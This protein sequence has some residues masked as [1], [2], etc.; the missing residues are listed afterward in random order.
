MLEEFSVGEYLVTLKEHA[1]TCSGTVYLTF[2]VMETG[3]LLSS[4][5]DLKTLLE[6]VFASAR[7]QS[8]F[9]SKCKDF[10]AA[11]PRPVCLREARRSTD[12][13]GDVRLL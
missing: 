5:A 7:L 8:D 6:S 11:H 2:V 10:V 12:G 13:V 4:G 1:S 3:S 9:I